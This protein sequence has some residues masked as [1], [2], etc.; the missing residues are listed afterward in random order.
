MGLQKWLHSCFFE[1]SKFF[2]IIMPAICRRSRLS[3]NLPVMSAYRQREVSLL[4]PKLGREAEIITAGM[5]QIADWQ[6][7]DFGQAER[8]FTHVTCA[9]GCRPELPLG[10]ALGHICK[11]TK[12][13]PRG[14]LPNFTAT[15]PDLVP[16]C[17]IGS[18]DRSYRAT[19][20]ARARRRLT[21]SY[22]LMSGV[23]FSQR[24]ASSS[25]RRNPATSAREIVPP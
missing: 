25:P 2:R 12:A 11:L 6:V 23:A 20:S 7:P 5:G 10:T 14:I 18:R 24:R 19:C 17:P 15:R 8:T 21:P 1:R 13:W 4:R 22:Q 9:V 3:D 16:T